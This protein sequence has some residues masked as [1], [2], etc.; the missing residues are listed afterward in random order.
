MKTT[1]GRAIG[2]VMIALLA[3]PAFAATPAQTTL[4]E[5]ST[6]S[7]E[8]ALP[9]SSGQKQVDKLLRQLSSN[10]LTVSKHADQLE[11]FSRGASR[12]HYTTH[13]AELNGARA[14]INAMNSDLQQ[15]QELRPVA[16]PWQQAL[17][18]RM[19]AVQAE[20]ASNAT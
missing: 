12:L 4:F 16:L 20:M 18:D 6:R 5:G 9:T 15:L 13:V 10:A 8:Q 3:A 11:S 1:F 14:A 19:Q 17:T 2:S 7:F